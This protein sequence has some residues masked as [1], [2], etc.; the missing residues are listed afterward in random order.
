[1]DRSRPR[2]AFSEETV[3][4]FDELELNFDLMRSS[5]LRPSYGR[6][7]C[8]WWGSGSR[9]RR[10]RAGADR[11]AHGVPFRP[12]FG[13]FESSP[14]GGRSPIGGGGFAAWKPDLKFALRLCGGHPHVPP[15]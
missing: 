9:S 4:L 13:C 1:M 14:S 2:R 3:G 8:A 7:T 5:G 12:G 10:A 6:R 15:A 11:G